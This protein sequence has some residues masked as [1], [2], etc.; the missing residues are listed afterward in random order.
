MQVLFQYPER[1]KLGK[2]VPKTKFY[3][4]SKLTKQSKNS[5]ISDIAQIVW[6]YNISPETV[7]LPATKDVPEIQI[8]KV[9]L[10][11][12]EYDID[13][14]NVIDESIPFPTLFELQYDQESKTVAAFKR[15]N[16]A[17]AV[18]WVISDYFEGEWILSNSTRTPM[19]VAVNLEGLYGQLL[20]TIMPYSD[21]T[22]ENIKDRVLRTEQI[23]QVEKEIIKCETKLQIEKQYNIKVEINAELRKLNK[24]LKDLT[25]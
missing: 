23:R 21:K 6:L 19:P 5:F 10:K 18:K 16:E 4:Y 9:D 2:I 12:K 13:L 11:I 22:G 14:I 25:K 8:F 20:K 24:K 7:N 17:S 15:P 1:A 3:K